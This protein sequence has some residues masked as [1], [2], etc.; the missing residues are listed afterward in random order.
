MTNYGQSGGQPPP[1]WQPTQPPYGQQPTSPD[2]SRPR[3]R[4][5]ADKIGIQ[6]PKPPAIP[7]PGLP[8]LPQRRRR[9]RPR[10]AIG[11]GTT[12]GIGLVG[13]IL[14]VILIPGE[15]ITVPNVVGQRLDVAQRTLGPDFTSQSRDATSQNR[16]QL[17]DSNWTVIRQDPAAGKAVAKGSL[18]ILY[19]DKVEAP[20]APAT[21][22]QPTT[23]ATDDSSHDLAI[24]SC[25]PNINGTVAAT[26]VATN[27]GPTIRGYIY[28]IHFVGKDGTGFGD[29]SGSIHA[30]RPGEHSL[31]EIPAGVEQA[32][33]SG[34]DCQL[35]DVK[36]IEAR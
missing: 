17:I 25:R 22:S 6:P 10:F 9:Q 19:A 14:I 8:N 29:F 16:M 3:W 26:V 7:R 28:T 12:L 11:C 34:Y 23:A 30:V 32:P 20:A 35:A 1:P 31:P 4:Q 2:S 21:T 5:L 15:K 33:A 13:I 27:H 18:I 36:V 24:T